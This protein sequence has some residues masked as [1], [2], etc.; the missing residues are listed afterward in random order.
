MVALAKLVPVITIDVPPVVTPLEG[1]TET[2]V[3][4]GSGVVTEAAAVVDA[5]TPTVFFAT[6]EIV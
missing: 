6:T 4:V 5:L 1:A 3:G 2:T